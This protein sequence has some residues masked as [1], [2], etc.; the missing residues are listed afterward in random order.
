MTIH[1]VFAAKVQIIFDMEYFF[2]FFFFLFF[3]PYCLF[4]VY[5]FVV[6]Q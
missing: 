2:F 6:M 4:T 5:Q 1:F 3:I